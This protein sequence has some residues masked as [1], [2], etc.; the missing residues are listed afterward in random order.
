[1]KKIFSLFLCLAILVASANLAFASESQTEYNDNT[2]P[3]KTEDIV[4]DVNKNLTRDQ[5]AQRFQTINNSYKI[6]EPFSK[7]DSEFVRAYANPT[8]KSAATDMSIASTDTLSIDNLDDANGVYG[9]IYGTIFSTTGTLNHSFGGNL[10]G[11]AASST[12]SISK[13]TVYV[14]HTAYGIIGSDGVGLVYNKTISASSI[15]TPIYFNKSQPYSAAVLYT[16]TTCW[17]N[18]KYDNGTLTV[19]GN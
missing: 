5:I 13:L 3:I 15:T 8:N 6:G 1:M 9:R 17:L 18:V 7:E 11:T 14:Q 10:T 12:H 4:C 19:V 2:S 16:S